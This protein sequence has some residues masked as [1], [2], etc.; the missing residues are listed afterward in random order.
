MK[1]SLMVLLVVLAVLTAVGVAA[2]EDD[3]FR[4]AMVMP[5]KI[6]DYSFSQSMYEAL[7]KLSE[8]YPEGKI[9][10]PT[11]VKITPRVF[12]KEVNP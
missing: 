5:S 12:T 10:I 1:K 8:S 7:V 9:I 6:N 11:M 2:A 4:V 3:V